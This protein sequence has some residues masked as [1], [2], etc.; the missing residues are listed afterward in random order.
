VLQ[1]VGLAEVMGD[2][3]DLSPLWMGGS[4]DIPPAFSEATRPM[5]L[6]QKHKWNNANL[7]RSVFEQGL[8]L[9]VRPMEGGLAT[10]HRV[11]PGS[12]RVADVPRIKALAGLIKQ[13]DAAAPAWVPPAYDEETRKALQALG[14][15]DAP[16]SAPAAGL[17][18][19]PPGAV[20]SPP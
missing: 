14:Y 7:E 4:I 1:R 13:W 2:G 20:G 8:Q 17:S 19:A 10:L 11:A 6:E 18:P 5:N 3:L 9:R 12:P 16:G 15:L